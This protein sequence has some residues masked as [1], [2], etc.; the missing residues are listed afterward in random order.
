MKYLVALSLV[1]G[2]Q[3]FSMSRA[4]SNEQE[5]VNCCA[6]IER[7][8]NF[9]LKYTDRID[10]ARRGAIESQSAQY[11]EICGCKPLPLKS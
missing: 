4:P 11:A 7:N 9:N 8:M 6:N 2:C 10:D 1:V 5:R 3:P